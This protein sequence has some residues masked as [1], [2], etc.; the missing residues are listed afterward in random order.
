MYF[1]MLFFIPTLPPVQVLWY[2]FW[3]GE[4]DQQ[5][6]PSILE[7]VGCQSPFLF[8]PFSHP[9]CFTLFSNILLILCNEYKLVIIQDDNKLTMVVTTMSTMT[10]MST[11]SNN[12]DDNDGNIDNDNCN[13]DDDDQGQQCQCH[14]PILHE[15]Y[16]LYLSMM[17]IR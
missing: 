6:S 5:I 9:L 13:N 3:F 12:D 16:K 10:T 1:A 8:F 15:E 2:F 17:M 14:Q 7:M 4:P 11:S